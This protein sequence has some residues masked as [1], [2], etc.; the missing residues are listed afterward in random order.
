MKVMQICSAPVGAFLMKRV[1]VKLLMVT[2][3]SIMLGSILISTFMKTWWSFVAFYAVTQSIGIGIVYWV[4][5]ICA[6]EW[7]PDRKGLISGLI[8]GAFGFGAFFFSFLSTAIANPNNL[9]AAV[10][11]GSENTDKFF[12]KEVASRVPYML[13]ICLSC[14]AM[15]CFVAIVGVTRKPEFK[16]KPLS[17]A[18]A[19]GTVA[20]SPSDVVS[21]K[22]AFTS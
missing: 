18:S 8:I 13:R 20:R 4:P 21:F 1:P 17:K 3:A 11:Q 22:Q 2:G 5:I 15:L 9:A 7:F 16:S 6:W 19:K 14:W 10:I 12:P